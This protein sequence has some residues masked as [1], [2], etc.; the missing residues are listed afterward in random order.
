MKEERFTKE[1]KASLDKKVDEIIANEKGKSGYGYKSAP[2]SP[3]EKVIT[4]EKQPDEVT[5][6]LG[7]M[8]PICIVRS[9]TIKV[10]WTFTEFILTLYEKIDRR[11]AEKRRARVKKE[12]A[13]IVANANKYGI[14]FTVRSLSEVIK[15]KKQADG[16][17]KR[18][19]S[20]GRRNLIL[21]ESLQ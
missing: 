10:P 3:L 21:L 1:H 6:E 4:I 14:P 11:F 17:I 19:K 9:A 13:D 15:T 20:N 7:S 16:F 2:N 5:G 8:S 12:I 18:C